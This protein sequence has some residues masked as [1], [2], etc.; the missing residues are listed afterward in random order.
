M[1]SVYDMNGYFRPTHG[2]CAAFKYAVLRSLDVSYV[3]DDTPYIK[4]SQFLAISANYIAVYRYIKAF[5]AIT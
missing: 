5:S 3:K 1:Y 4:T 2:P